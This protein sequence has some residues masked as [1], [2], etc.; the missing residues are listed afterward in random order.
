MAAIEI[1]TE[2]GNTAVEWDGGLAVFGPGAFIDAAN[3]GELGKDAIDLTGVSDPGEFA[4]RI[5]TELAD[6][7]N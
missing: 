5:T 4:V 2:L 7:D 3:S 1:H 6:T